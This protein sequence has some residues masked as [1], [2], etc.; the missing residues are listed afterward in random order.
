MSPSLTLA[1]LTRQTRTAP[2]AVMLTP[3]VACARSMRAR[4]ASAAPS[5]TKVAPVSTKKRIC[6][7][8]MLPG[9]TKWPFASACSVVVGRSLPGEDTTLWPSATRR[10]LPPISKTAAPDSI[11]TSF[12]PSTVAAPTA[13]VC[14][15][16][17]SITT[18]ALPGRSPTSATSWAGALKLHAHNSGSRTVRAGITAGLSP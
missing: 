7:P 15:L 11:L 14:R 17:A 6:T 13:M 1:S 3:G 16:P 5:E 4:R 12:T 9:T 2:L 8:L 18:M 10:I